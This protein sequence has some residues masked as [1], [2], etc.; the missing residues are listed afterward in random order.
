MSERTGFLSAAEVAAAQVLHKRAPYAITGISCGMFSIARH[1]GG[2]T[3]QGCGYTYIPEHDE[4]IRNDVLKLVVSL[5]K[6]EAKANRTEERE[7][8]KAAQGALL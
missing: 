8:A 2:M 5:R 1:Y 3:Y 7:R 6:L 4:C